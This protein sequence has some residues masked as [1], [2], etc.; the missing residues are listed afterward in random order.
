MVKLRVL[1][2]MPRHQGGGAAAIGAFV[3]RY[4]DAREFESAVC[5]LH[6]SPPTAWSE[7]FARQ[8]I[9]EFCCGRRSAHDLRLLGDLARVIRDFRPDVIQ[10]HHYVWRYLYMLSLMRRMPPVVHTLHGVMRKDELR[11]ENFMQRLAFRSRRLLPVAVSTAVADSVSCTIGIAPCVIKNGIPLERFEKPVL[12][13]AEW[14]RA[15]GFGQEE[16]LVIVVAR[17]DPVKRLDLLL[18]AFAQV[19]NR[20]GVSARLIFVGDG[21]LREEL[22]SLTGL[23][24]LE[25]TVTFLGYRNDIPDALHAADVFVLTSDSEANPVSVMEAMASGL[26]V[27]CRAVGGIPELVEDGCN[28]RLI[29]E[30]TPG[31]I[32]DT[33][34]DLLSQPE[35]RARLGVAARETAFREFHSAAMSA[36]YAAFYRRVLQGA[37]SRQSQ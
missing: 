1:H 30:G 26:P 19:R 18:E 20:I 4:L 15:N 17:F 5:T 16:L 7:C 37:G 13:R 32:A 36:Q 34:G 23:L 33:L 35:L 29:R 2:C 8:N 11:I 12:E 10:S 27:A 31:A 22:L 24:G 14:R 28:G 21:P 6:R 25:Q 9:R 3:A